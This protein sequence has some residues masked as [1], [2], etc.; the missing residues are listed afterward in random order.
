MPGMDGWQTSQRIRALQTQGQDNNAA[1]VVMVTAHGREVLSQRSAQDQALLNGFLVKPVTA[2]M[3]SD[4]VADAKAAMAR[5]PG[6]PD[7]VSVAATHPAK[8]KRLQGLRLLVVEDNKINQLVAQ[9]LLTQEGAEITLADDGLL[10]VDAVAHAAVPFDVVLMDLQMPVMDGFTATRTIREQLGLTELP[11]IAMTA[12]VMASDRAACLAAGMNDHVG[13]PFELNHLVSVLLHHVGR[14]AF[15]GQATDSAPEHRAA[16]VDDVPVGALQVEG[17]QLNQA[18][19]RMGGNTAMYAQAL[20]SFV[21]DLPAKPAELERLLVAGTGADVVRML[22]TL[23]GLSA[24][25][26]AS[27]LSQTVAQLE[28][29]C[30]GD[31]A[32]LN[33]DALVDQLQTAITLAMQRIAPVLAHYAPAPQAVVQAEG[34]APLDLA[35]FHADLQALVELLR[36][37]DMRAMDAHMQ[38]QQRGGTQKQ[39]QLQ[40]LREAMDK[41]DFAAALQICEGLIANPL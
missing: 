15:A 11:I 34:A 30:K 37:S 40:P 39:T 22:H 33:A 13:K 31:L 6:G 20:Q 3:L 25:V 17:M 29:T 7:P 32:Q 18:L 26:G 8:P 9:G 24:T 27:A 12:N 38:L 28:K 14:P 36:R 41:L 5:A 1:V 35:L 21:N 23:K 10:G 4:A 19:A 2:S 16:P